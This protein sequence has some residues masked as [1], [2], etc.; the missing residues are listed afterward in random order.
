MN[1]QVQWV[2]ERAD[3]N[4][5]DDGLFLGERKP[6]RGRLGCADRNDRSGVGTNSLGAQVY[7]VDCAN[8]FNFR[9]SIWLAAFAGRGRRFDREPAEQIKLPFERSY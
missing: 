3:C 7:T 5:D 9:V 6:A 4:N 1:D 2:I 8:D